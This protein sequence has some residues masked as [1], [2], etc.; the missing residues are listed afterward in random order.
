MDCSN[1]SVWPF[2]LRCFSSSLEVEDVVFS[3]VLLDSILTFVPEAL[4]CHSLQPIILF[5]KIMFSS[6]HFQSKCCPNYTI[7]FTLYLVFNRSVVPSFQ[8]LSPYQ[9]LIQFLSFQSECCPKL[10]FLVPLLLMEC[11]QLRHLRC[12]FFLKWLN[13]FQSSL[14]SLVCRRSNLVLLLLFPFLFSLWCHSRSRDEIL[15]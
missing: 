15:S 4:W 3:S 10:F 11:F 9:V 6:Y 13:L 1:K 12:I 14:V 2:S 7:L 5:V 8:V